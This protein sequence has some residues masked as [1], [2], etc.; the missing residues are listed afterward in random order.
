MHSLDVRNFNSYQS[1]I[2]EREVNN[3]RIELMHSFAHP[4]EELEDQ[5]SPRTGDAPNFG[6]E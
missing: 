2:E 3:N 1:A 6:L 4:I 5:Q